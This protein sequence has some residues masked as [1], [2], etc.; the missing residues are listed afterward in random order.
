MKALI[1]AALLVATG[2]NAAVVESTTNKAGGMLIAT[3]EAVPACGAGWWLFL[4]TKPTGEILRGCWQL[5]YLGVHVWYDD[6]TEYTYP[7]KGWVD[8]PAAAAFFAQ[9][10]SAPNS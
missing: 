2:T 4:S 8:G 9:P 1:L 3:D 6:H 5:S 7:V 10:Q